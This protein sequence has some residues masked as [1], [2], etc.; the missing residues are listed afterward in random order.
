MATGLENL[1]IYQ[2][3]EQ[4]ELEVYELTKE[5]PVDEKYRSIDQLRRSSSS[6]VNNI[7]EAYNKKSLKDK[8]RILVDIVKCE[9][10][11]TKRNLIVCAK[12]NFCAAESLKISEKYTEIL[13]ATSGYIKF[14][15]NLQT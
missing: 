12:K 13:K 14:L 6:V 8:I 15:R 7:A 1:K 3:A 11:E 4:A 5:Y 2:M 9:A 10:E